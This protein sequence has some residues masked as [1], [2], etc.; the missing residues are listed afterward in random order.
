MGIIFC[1]EFEILNI[2]KSINWNT[3]M[4]KKINIHAATEHFCVMR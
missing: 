3:N 4:D 2:F 1:L